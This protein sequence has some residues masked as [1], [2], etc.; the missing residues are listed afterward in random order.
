MVYAD[1]QV[2]SGS[3]E[4][5]QPLHQGMPATLTGRKGEGCHVVQHGHAGAEG[6]GDED[7][8][9]HGTHQSGRRGMGGMATTLISCS[10]IHHA[11]H[12]H[13]VHANCYTACNAPLANTA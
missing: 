8:L 3:S 11:L 5:T 10:G 13:H 4:L 1:A 12:P 6:H 2:G 7:D 9:R